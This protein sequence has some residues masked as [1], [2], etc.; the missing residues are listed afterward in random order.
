MKLNLHHLILSAAVS[1]VLV[2]FNP[3]FSFAQ[4]SE[5]VPRPYSEPSNQETN[6]YENETM[7]EEDANVNKSGTSAYFAKDSIVSSTSKANQQAAHRQQ[8]TRGNSDASKQSENQKQVDKNK[9][10]K[11]SIL[12]FNFIYYILKK[13]KWSD[14]VD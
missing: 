10:E 12:S 14:I 11:D 7:S 6:L 2:V 5:I 9:E 4:E 1:T 3:M 13:F 8:R